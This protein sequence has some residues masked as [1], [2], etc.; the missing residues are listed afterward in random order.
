MT[1]APLV[2]DPLAFGI[3]FVV[4]VA[5]AF[6]RS[7]TESL[8]TVAHEGGHMAALAVTGRGHRGF[9]LNESKDRE[10][11]ALTAGGTDPIDSSFGV[12]LWMSIFAGYAT[13]PLIGLGGAHALAAGNGWGVLWAGIVLLIVALLWANNGFARAVTALGLAGVLWAALAGGPQTQAAVA[14]APLAGRNRWQA[15]A[16]RSQLGRCSRP[17]ARHHTGAQS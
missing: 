7:W 8:V 5:Y 4:L 3:G 14:F 17:E 11:N 15:A 12:G 6:A 2:G 13:P 1:T 16:G 10:G 9:E